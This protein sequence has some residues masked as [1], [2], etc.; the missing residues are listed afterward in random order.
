MIG[1]ILLFDTYMSIT[2][3]NICVLFIL[4]FTIIEN[5]FSFF[6]YLCLTIGNPCVLLLLVSYY[7]YFFCF[8]LTCILLLVILVFYSHLYLTIFNPCV[9]LLL[10]SYYLQSLCFTLTYIWLFVIF[11]FYSYLILL[12]QKK[13]FFFF[14]D[15]CFTEF[16]KVTVVQPRKKFLTLRKIFEICMRKLKIYAFYPL[17]QF[18]FIIFHTY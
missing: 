15:L 14:S 17:L 2:F 12:L 8:T 10:V 16:L 11:L 4:F 5:V 18:F 3:C 9:L 13:Y 7:L 6:S 1:V